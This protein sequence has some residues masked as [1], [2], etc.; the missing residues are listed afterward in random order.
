[1]ME[2]YIYRS[3]WAERPSENFRNLLGPAAGSAAAWDLEQECF[4]DGGKTLQKLLAIRVKFPYG[5]ISL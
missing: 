2:V 3:F 4:D 1:M 5:R